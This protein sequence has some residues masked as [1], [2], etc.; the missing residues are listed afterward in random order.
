MDPKTKKTFSLLNLS[1]KYEKMI[2]FDL[3][4]HSKF[5]LNLNI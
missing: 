5:D 4:K 3:A 2:L 1:Q